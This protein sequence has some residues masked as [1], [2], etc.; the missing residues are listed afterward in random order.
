M[1][2]TKNIVLSQKITKHNVFLLKASSLVE[3]IDGKSLSVYVH[4]LSQKPRQ[5]KGEGTL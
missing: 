5:R 1:F 2:T 4:E 3:K